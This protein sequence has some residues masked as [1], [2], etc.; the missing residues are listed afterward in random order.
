MIQLIE[1]LKSKVSFIKLI[2]FLSIF[3]LALYIING[4]LLGVAKLK[5]MTGG[6]G[7]LDLE[8]GYSVERAYEILK[9]LGDEGREYYLKYIIP[10]DFVFPATYMLFFASAFLYILKHTL[11]ADKRFNLVLLIPVITMLLDYTENILVI[12]MLRH[13]PEIAEGLAKAA[14]VVTRLKFNLISI[15]A[16]IIVILLAN[17]LRK[18]F[19]KISER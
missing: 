16:A 3:L 15:N 19:L 12:N 10:M 6:T 8:N 4:E 1:G 11:N 17:L 9:G 5:N 13:F 14:D 18:R 2:I 7:I